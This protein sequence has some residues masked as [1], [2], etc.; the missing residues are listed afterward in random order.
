[1]SNIKSN[2]ISWL[3]IMSFMIMTVPMLI[4]ADESTSATNIE[5]FKQ[6]RQV[7][8]QGTMLK[9]LKVNSTAVKATPEQERNLRLSNALTKAK[10]HNLPDLGESSQIKLKR[11]DRSVPQQQTSA[12]YELRDAEPISVMYNS[13]EMSK[14]ADSV[15]FNYYTG[16]LGLDSIDMDVM[17]SSNEGTNFG[18]EG[19]WINTTF[20]PG[21]SDPSL[22]HFY[23]PMGTLD[24]VNIVPAVDDPL[25]PYTT[26]SWD[27]PGGNNYQFLAVGNLW[28]IYTR[29]TDMYVVME[30]TDV[31]TYGSWFAFDYM[32][33]TNGS[34]VFDDGM[35]EPT[36][37]DMTVNGEYADTLEIGSNPYFEITLDTYMYG[38]IGVFWDTNHNG[39]L[40]D[41]DL[42][43][44]FYEFMDN[45]MHDE[46]SAKG[47]F[48]FTYTD[49]MADGLNYL[50][51]DLVFAAFSE[52]DM[53]VT[54][55]QFYTMPSPFSVSG[56]IY[57][58]N[59]GGA[60]LGGIVVWAMYEDSE[61]DE[62]PAVIVVTDGAG[63]YHIDLPDTGNVMIGSEDHFGMTD[64]LMPDPSHHFVNVQG[65]EFG[66]NFYYIAP[67]SGIEGFVYDEMGAPIEGV[68]VKAGGDD[69]PGSYGYTSEIGYYYIGVMPGNYDVGINM[70]ML[71]APYVVPQS[72]YV[73]V[74]DF[75]VETVNF[76]LHSA[77][78]SIV[79]AVTL[80]GVYYEGA[81]VVAMNE[82]GFSYAI[83]ST[84]GFFDIP[85]H[86]GPET[87]Y[88]LMVWMP[89]MS[90]IIQ[91]S[92]NYMTPAGAEGVAVALETISGGLFGFFF[93]GDTKE[94]IMGSEEI[95]MMMRD[96]DTGMEFYSGPDYNGYYEVYAPAGL[97]EVMAGGYEWTAMGVDSILIADAMIEHDF[98]LYHQSFDA[99]LEGYVFDEAGMPVPF[100]QVQIG[101][102]GWGSGTMSDEFGYYYFDL[103][104]GYYYVSAQAPGFNMYFDELPVGPGNN[105]Y[106]FFLE[107]FQVDGAIAGSVYD[108]DSGAPLMD[109]NVYAYS[110]DDDE[111][112]WTYT[113]STGGFWFGLPNGMYD[114]VVEHWEYP[115]M[116]IDEI[117]VNNDTTFIEVPM[118][119]PD[120]GVDGYVYDDMGSPIYDA[121]VFIVSL[122]DSTTGFWGE[123]DDNG[124]FSIPALNGEYMVFAAADGYNPV[125]SGMVTIMNNW[126]SIDIYMYER[127]FATPPSINFIFDQPNDQG[128]WVRMQF[129]SGGTEWGPFQAFSIWRLTNTPMG[130][131]LDFVDYLPNHEMDSYNLVL[132][133]LVDSSTYV[134][135]PEDYMSAFMVT[136]HWDMYEYIDGVPSAGYSIDNIHP[137]IPGP[138]TLLSSTEDGVEIGWEMSMADDFQYFEVYRATNPE[139]TN[140]D[141]YATVDPMFTDLD[142]TIGQTY[143]YMVSA[144]DANGNLGEG[145]N[146]VTN[147]IV[148]VDDLEMMPT[149]YGLS[150]NYPNPFNPTTT[151]EFALPVASEV[152]LE[153]YNLL[154]QK[155]RTL[156]NGY[157]PAG[158]INTSWDGMDQNG[159]EISSGTYIYRLQTADQ[160]FSKKMVLMK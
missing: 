93:D 98:Y 111:G 158:Y 11:T 156:V 150:Q 3:V 75:S 97:Y 132:P 70:E 100:A 139:F 27:W 106:N 56:S 40:D 153:I 74:A 154:G 49:E 15:Y 114:V 128:R 72:E 89:D 30:V 122:L 105:T 61:D 12:A 51:D 32:I 137:G 52:M 53:A 34:N 14:V 160:S 152:S 147:A 83:S 45:D 134:S 148:S 39:D 76:T 65:P 63:Q 121:E 57:E 133:T 110:Y 155:V 18:S 143:Y 33:Q 104:V 29:T 145:T 16:M 22:L 117:T 9:N 109:A 50:A 86:G 138:L 47:V 68:E 88:D 91:V 140:A 118:T 62:Q 69:G 73:E 127:E 5:K 21:F 102:E 28:V 125:Q 1:M 151:I 60:P 120:G 82:L 119:L 80:D 107:S 31:D 84:N 123:T 8:N 81:T 77:N 2:G 112:Y 115:P 96:T 54:S 35:V 92:D 42:P 79:G 7:Q 13:G 144:V 113:D 159:K 101:N 24:T 124:Y 43:L 4:L 66:Y 87:L 23:S 157:V 135:N 58:T 71:P 10:Q 38:E 55:V 46:D 116:W 126:V 6:L 44:E 94:P 67:T 129:M 90:N 26:I 64:G 78:N 25:A 48:G 149:V 36:A 103:P 59:G 130:P 99:S 17:I 131:I 20:Y 146:V 85:V 142:A 141:T 41:D 37:Y 19:T 136:G 108:A 95:G